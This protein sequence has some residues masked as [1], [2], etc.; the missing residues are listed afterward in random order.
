MVN[1]LTTTG[2]A[3]KERARYLEEYLE[4]TRVER[5][6]EVFVYTGVYQERREAQTRTRGYISKE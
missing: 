3:C 4:R 5:Y 6:R 2:R 1:R